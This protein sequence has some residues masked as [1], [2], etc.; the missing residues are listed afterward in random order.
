MGRA[1]R[2]LNKNEAIHWANTHHPTGTTLDCMQFDRDSCDTHPD[3]LFCAAARHNEF[4]S[5]I[6]RRDLIKFGHVSGSHSDV[7]ELILCPTVEA[8]E[9]LLACPP[10][11]EHRLAG[12]LSSC[13]CNAT[14]ELLARKEN[15]H[16]GSYAMAGDYGTRPVAVI[17]LASAVF[18][19]GPL[20]VGW[21]C[22][23]CGGVSVGEPSLDP[24]PS[25]SAATAAVPYEVSVTHPSSPSV[26]HCQKPRVS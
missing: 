8:P 18:I 2:F 16:A 26:P 17:G 25:P 9:Q 13:T 5:I 6:V 23:L 12:G 4:D 15:G 1:L 22:S 10:S 11:V 14:G 24:L 21:V 20:A 7:I 19:G 3:A